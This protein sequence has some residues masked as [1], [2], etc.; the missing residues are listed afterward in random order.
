MFGSAVSDTANYELGTD[1]SRRRRDGR[2]DAARASGIACRVAG[3][4][5]LGCR[6]LTSAGNWGSVGPLKEG[7]C[8][9]R[10]R[11]EQNDARASDF[12]AAVAD[13]RFRF[14]LRP[15]SRPGFFNRPS[16]RRRSG[17]ALELDV[18]Q[19]EIQHRIERAILLHL[20]SKHEVW[21]VQAR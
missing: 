4:T 1:N 13:G 20:R 18:D 7:L 10:R 16:F 5:A 8:A 3:T 2:G 21:Y 12:T 6:T 11:G 17:W 14:E 19:V 15:S 9:F